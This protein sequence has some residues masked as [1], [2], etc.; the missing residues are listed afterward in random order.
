MIALNHLI[1]E[2]LIYEGLLHSV[3][4]SKFQDMIERWAII[5]DKI[6]L[7]FIK[8]DNSKIVIIFT[9]T[10]E[11]NELDNLLKLT[12]N[13]GWYISAVMGGDTMKWRKFD[14]EEFVDDRVRHMLHSVQAEAKFD[15]E[16]GMEDVDILY[17]VTPSI[18]DIK[19]QH[20]GLVPKSLNKIS[21]HPERIYFS[22]IRETLQWLAIRFNKLNAEIKKFSIYEVDIK[23]AM[24]NN[25]QIRLFRDP[26]FRDGIY[27]L[28][29]IHPQFLK[30]IEK[31]KI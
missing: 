5:N 30:F 8:D 16:L 24:R 1:K 26:N 19:I 3:S 9:R 17:H 6:K 29:N 21:Y 4:R 2:H 15:Q 27:T 13:L 25:S 12:D 7:L 14:K 11:L 23:A 31:I 28:S 10:P 20:I 18:N 22:K